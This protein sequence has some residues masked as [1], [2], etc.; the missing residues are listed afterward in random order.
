MFH[1]FALP[2]STMMVPPWALRTWKSMRFV[3][4]AW[5]LWQFTQWFCSESYERLFS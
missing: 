3:V 5:K 4:Y 1:F 2:F